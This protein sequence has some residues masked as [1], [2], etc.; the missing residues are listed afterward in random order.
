M[1]DSI[2]KRAVEQKPIEIDAMT[3]IKVK[4]RN[5]GAWFDYQRMLLHKQFPELLGECKK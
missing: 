1:T 4:M 3:R 2:N 5:H